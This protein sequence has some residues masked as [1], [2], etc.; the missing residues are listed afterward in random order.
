MVNA[1]VAAL[2]VLSLYPRSSF[3]SHV[4]KI[5]TQVRDPIAID[6]SCK[7][8][9]L[10]PPVFREAKLLRETKTGWAVELPGWLYPV[11]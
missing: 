2:Y 9:K 3:M 1:A 5:Q 10:K 11:V 7:R 8:L 6:L 4:V